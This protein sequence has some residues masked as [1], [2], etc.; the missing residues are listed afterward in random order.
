MTLPHTEEYEEYTQPPPSPAVLA[1]IY[2]AIDAEQLSIGEGFYVVAV[3]LA[4]CLAA[5][6]PQDRAMLIDAVSSNVRR[7]LDD[8]TYIP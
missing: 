3:L 4:R 7:W 1:R 6:K 8:F 5:S 2:S